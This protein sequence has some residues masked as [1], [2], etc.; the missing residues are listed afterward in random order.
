LD[1]HKH[2]DTLFQDLQDDYLFDNQKM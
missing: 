2:D 1:G